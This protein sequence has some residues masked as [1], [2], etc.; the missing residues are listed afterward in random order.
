MLNWIYLRGPYHVM[1]WIGQRWNVEVAPK[2]EVG[3]NCEACNRL[4]TTPGIREHIAEA[5]DLMAKEIAGEMT[6]LDALGCLHP[7]SV[8]GLWQNESQVRDDGAG[9]RRLPL[10][11][12]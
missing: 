9:R 12:A 2:S 10:L 5:A 8:L 6:V 4:F 1:E 11:P 7:T 3:G